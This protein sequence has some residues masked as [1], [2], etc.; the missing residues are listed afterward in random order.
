MLWYQINYYS[1][2]EVTSVAQPLSA[3][4][5]AQALAQVHRFDDAD[6]SPKFGVSLWMYGV[7]QAW[8]AHS[9]GEL[10]MKNGQGSLPKLPVIG[11]WRNR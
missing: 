6:A 3:A 7:G 5:L 8:G 2:S 11:S 4:T 1:E 10:T 9:V